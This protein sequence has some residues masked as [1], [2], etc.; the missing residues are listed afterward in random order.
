MLKVGDKAP[1]FTLADQDGEKHSLKDYL[2]SWVLIYFYPKDNTSGCTKEACS[3]RDQWGEYTK[4]GI[5]VLGISKDSEKSHK[6]FR[7]KYELPFTLLVD[8]DKKVIKKYGADKALGTKRISYLVSP[9]GTIVDVYSKV[10]T[11]THGQDVL[12]NFL[13]ISEL[14]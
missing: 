6:N 7:D 14:E 13:N 2:G 3:I 11:E 9:H 8:T 4:H 12:E 5:K 1:D 10:N